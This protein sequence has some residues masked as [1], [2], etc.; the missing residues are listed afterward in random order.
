MLILVEGI[1]KAG[2]STLIRNL[3]EKFGLAIY[4]KP[5]PAEIAPAGHHEY[6]K[7]VGYAVLGLHSCLSLSL[8]V[9]RSFISDFVYL[10]RRQPNPDL[11]VWQAWESTCTRRNVLL[12]YVSVDE[13][14]QARRL[15]C[16]PDAFTVVSDFAADT[17]SYETY[18]KQ[19]RFRVARIDGSAS[20]NTQLAAINAAIVGIPE[21]ERDAVLNGMSDRAIFIKKT[22]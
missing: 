5:I 22:H 8:I 9:D 17:A 12:V 14:T 13:A 2:K 6:F 21:L 18:M 1:D 11:G 16:E 3:G 20:F 19:T 7:G 10:N 15:I 4:R